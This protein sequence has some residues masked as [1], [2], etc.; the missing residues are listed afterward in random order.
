MTN[1]DEHF[2][3][4]MNDPEFAKDYMTKVIDGKNEE[5]SMLKVE[6]AR[7]KAKLRVAN[8]PTSQSPEETDFYRKAEGALKHERLQ[9]EDCTP[10]GIIG[11]TT[12]CQIHDSVEAVE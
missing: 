10:R 5:I 1:F 7:L 9:C 12:F 4:M 6:I 11:V 3:E 8:D 2:E